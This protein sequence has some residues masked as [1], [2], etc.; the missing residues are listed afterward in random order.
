MVPL[1][2][3]RARVSVGVAGRRAPGVV[4]G[5]WNWVSV[6]KEVGL[7]VCCCKGIDGGITLSNSA[8]DLL[9]QEKSQRRVIG[10]DFKDLPMTTCYSTVRW[11]ST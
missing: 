7:L 8:I 6:G 2:G 1:G 5:S 3:S 4:G 11:I 9:S 10:D